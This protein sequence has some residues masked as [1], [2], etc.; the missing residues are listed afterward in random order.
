MWFNRTYENRSR[1]ICIFLLYTH[2]RKERLHNSSI[3]CVGWRS[4]LFQF[5]HT[6]V[7][8]DSNEFTWQILQK[9]KKEIRKMEKSFF[10]WFASLTLNLTFERTK[11]RPSLTMKDFINVCKHA[12]TVQE[13]KFCFVGLTKKQRK[14]HLDLR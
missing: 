1:N 11:N 4:F 8:Q 5:F 2:I 9:E 6:Y 7:H 10:A 14:T 3:I 12:S 13:K